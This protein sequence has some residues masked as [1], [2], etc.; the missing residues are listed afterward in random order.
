MLSVPKFHF[1]FSQDKRNWISMYNLTRLEISFSLI[2]QLLTCKLEDPFFGGDP[3]QSQWP[4]SLV[5]SP[6]P[7]ALRSS[8]H[9]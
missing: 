4:G 1:Y 7:G 2:A 5:L 8:C 6:E 9:L 3:T